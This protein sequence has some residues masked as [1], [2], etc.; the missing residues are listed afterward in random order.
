MNEGFSMTVEKFTEFWDK[1]SDEWYKNAKVKLYDNEEIPVSKL[2]SIKPK[3]EGK[4][5][6][7]YSII[8]GIIKDS[9]FKNPRKKLSRYKRASVIAYTILLTDPLCYE[10][11]K[12]T[13]D[14]HFLKQRLA[15]FVAI[16]SIVQDYSES[17]INNL[18]SNGNSLYNFELLNRNVLPGN[19]SFLMGVYKDM[20]YSEI[21]HNF[22]VLTM[23]NVFRLLTEGYSLLKDLSP[24]ES[25]PPTEQLI[26]D[27]PC[28]PFDSFL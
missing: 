13:P 27:L 21:Y 12:S 11:R 25:Y 23:A 1:W 4:L 10:D 17:E 19:D 20:F 6:N 8:K 28:I 16:G 3:I 14:T 18:T 7:N 24:I 26:G 22:N 9:Y 2:C 5:Y 15:F